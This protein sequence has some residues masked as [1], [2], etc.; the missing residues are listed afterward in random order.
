MGANSLS[1]C[2]QSAQSIHAGGIDNQ[3]FLF[4]NF[5]S[6]KVRLELFNDTRVVLLEDPSEYIF[7][8]QG[9]WNLAPSSNQAPAGTSRQSSMAWMQ[10]SFCPVQEHRPPS[11]GFEVRSKCIQHRANRCGQF[12]VPPGAF[13]H[14][15]LLVE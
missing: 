12:A 9:L 8:A 6:C 10:R 7:L 13:S 15:V 5:K 11:T 14:D 2:R 3:L 4:Q 1:K